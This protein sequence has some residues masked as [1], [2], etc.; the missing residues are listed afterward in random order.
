MSNSALWIGTFIKT[1]AIILYD[2][3]LQ[4]AGHEWVN[5]YS[6]NKDGVR[7]F[8]RSVVREK[9]RHASPAEKE[10]AL[11]AY[12]EW[13]QKDN[14]VFVAG[15]LLEKEKKEKER[16]SDLTNKEHQTRVERHKKFLD[17]IGKTGEARFVEP[18]NNR[19]THC[20]SCKCNL[21]SNLNLECT[22]CHWLICECGACGCGYSKY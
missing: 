3:K 2:P 17:K 16:T 7:P 6:I 4:I 8:E 1:G 10:Q 13:E 21:S 15:E 22:T 19:A 12:A 5:L 18:C 11:R 9:I 20:Y 14:G